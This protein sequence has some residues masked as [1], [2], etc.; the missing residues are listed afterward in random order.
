MELLFGRQFRLQATEFKEVLQSGKRFVAKDLV[1]VVLQ[2]KGEEKKIGFS[3]SRKVGPSVKRNQIKR[4]LREAFRLNQHQIK[5]GF[6]TTI[7]VRPSQQF[8]TFGDV[9]DAFLNLLNKA[10]LIIKK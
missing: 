10:G 7:I 6:Y 3:L 8:K 5:S 2:D 1:A 9:Q 4:W